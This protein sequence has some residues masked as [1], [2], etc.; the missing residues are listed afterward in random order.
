MLL[1]LHGASSAHKTDLSHVQGCRVVIWPD[2]D[3]PGRKYADQIEA[4]LC[5]GFSTKAHILQIADFPVQIAEF[6]ATNGTD[7]NSANIDENPVEICAGWDAADA[8][9][10]GWG[11]AEIDALIA[12]ALQADETPVLLDEV[13]PSRSL[14]DIEVWK[15]PD[16][17]PYATLRL[18]GHFEHWPIASAAFKKFLSYQHY[19]DTGKMLSQSALDDQRRT[20]EGQALY[21]GEAHPV[22]NRIGT[23]GRTLYVD[24]GDVSW[25]AI[26]INSEGWQVIDHPPARFTRA[27]SMQPLPIPAMSGGDINL[28]RPFLN[29]A[30]E[31][32]FQMLVAWLIGCFHPKGPYPILILNGEQGS[33]KSTT[34][35]VLR[36]LI[37]PATCATAASESV[38]FGCPRS[39]A[40]E[41][42]WLVWN[43][44]YSWKNPL[45][46]EAKSPRLTAHTRRQQAGF[47]AYATCCGTAF[48]KEGAQPT[49]S[50]LAR[51]SQKG[52]FSPGRLWQQV[53]VRHW[54]FVTGAANGS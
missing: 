3:L 43:A 21:D 47:S 8:I 40:R 24:I 4:A 2:N 26:A 30:N 39:S 32:D 22:F 52:P 17:E 35:R 42:A 14:A 38:S 20:Y 41:G 27:R 11:V 53:F 25:K 46:I 9:S 51:P 28:L 45:S 31:A 44:E 29:T 49:L 13:A 18:D 54:P 19:Q 7:H 6:D 16:G 10:N 1:C 48:G 5:T 50:A 23:L 37:D 12:H 36:N 33:T 34:A 15:T